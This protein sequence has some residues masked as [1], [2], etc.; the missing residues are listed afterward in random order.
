MP[1]K[2]GFIW[3]TLTCKA[4]GVR[5]GREVPEKAKDP[6]GAELNWLPEIPLGKCWR[7]ITSTYF[8]KYWLTFR[9]PLLTF[10][11]FSIPVFHTW[12]QIVGCFSELTCN[13]SIVEFDGRPAIA[14]ISCCLV[15]ETPGGPLW[16]T[17]GW[18]GR[19][20]IQFCST[21]ISNMEMKFHL[22]NLNVKRDC[23]PILQSNPN[24]I[25]SVTRPIKF[26]GVQS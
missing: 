23:S 9:N 16:D 25:Y 26:N 8:S 10:G 11:W 3:Y 4:A 13:G 12:L 2:R 15:R 17:G 14:F 20:P 22:W 19:A 24:H 7:L 6:S 21:Q 5:K 18:T 1:F